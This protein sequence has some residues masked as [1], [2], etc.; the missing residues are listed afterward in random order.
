VRDN[1]TSTFACRGSCLLPSGQ[2]SLS[3]SSQASIEPQLCRQELPLKRH[4]REF[5]IENI[6]EANDQQILNEK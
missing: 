6:S 5:F 3:F 2:F 1:G 4:E